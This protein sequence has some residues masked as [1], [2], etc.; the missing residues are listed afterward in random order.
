MK[1]VVDANM[2]DIIVKETY[3]RGF[4]PKDFVLFAAGGAGASHC[5]GFGFHSKL[6]RIVVFPFSATFCA[7]GSAGMDIVHIYEQSRRLVLMQPEERGYFEDYDEFNAVVERL[8]RQALRDMGGEHAL[9][10]GL[11]PW[12]RL[13]LEMKFGGQVHVLRVNSPRLALHSEDDVKAICRAFFQEFSDM[14]GSVAMYPQGGIEIQNFILHSILPQPK[15]ELPHYPLAGEKVSKSAHKGE[16]PAYWEE[17]GGY[18]P[19][20]ILDRAELKPQN[21]IEGPAI[22]EGKDT[23]VVLHPG[24]KLTVDRYLN[25]L[26]EKI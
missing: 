23:S 9:R 14:Y 25:F 7:L 24:T 5:C 19:T 6:D 16:R 12:V 18:R 2:G 8:R 3:L 20:P 1:R 26:I 10:D 17:C 21:I 13:E 22:I 15:I 4:D 11:T